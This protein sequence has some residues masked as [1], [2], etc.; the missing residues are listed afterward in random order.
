M[1]CEQG[2]TPIVELLVQHDPKIAKILLV[3]S[4]GVTPLH[5]AA[6]S[7]SFGIAKILIDN[8]RTYPGG[9]GGRVCF[10]QIAYGDAL[11]EVRTPYPLK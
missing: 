3:N 7:N 1:A 9:G 10:L 4:D 6:I 2:S 5:Q 11:H 8:V